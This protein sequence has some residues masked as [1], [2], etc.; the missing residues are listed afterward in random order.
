M[1]L[2]DDNGAPEDFKVAGDKRSFADLIT[3]KGLAEVA[4]Y[5][6]GVIVS[7]KLIFPRDPDGTLGQPT[8]LIQRAHKAGLLIHAFTF[9]AE[10]QYLPKEFRKGTDPSG[11]GN[12]A[13]EARAFFRAGLDGMFT[14]H[15]DQAVAG[16]R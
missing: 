6:D 14:N 12:L 10:N 13:G 2:V 8:D 3:D 1:Q 5:A 11:L 9:R 16:R 7:K 15:P 4:T